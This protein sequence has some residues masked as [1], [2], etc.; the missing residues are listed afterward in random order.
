MPTNDDPQLYRALR[1]VSLIALC[2]S[3]VACAS[4]GPVTV[5]SPRPA[6]ALAR[7]PAVA[8]SEPPPTPTLPVAAPVAAPVETP[9]PPAE[10]PP[11]GELASGALRFRGHDE[12]ALIGQMAT[13]EVRRVIERFNS[14]TLVFHLDL[15]DGY[16]IAFKPARRGEGQWWR[17][18]I[19]GYRLARALQ[20]TA[21]VPPAVSRTVPLRVLEGYLRDANLEVDAQGN[22]AGAAI[23][24][25]P[26][27][28]RTDLQSEA[29]RAVWN[30]WL[31]PT[32]PIAQEHRRR[33][34]QLATLIVFDYLQANF[35]RWNSANIRADEGDDLVFRDNNRAWYPEN[36]RL[37]T[38]GGLAGIRRIPRAL[39]A[40]IE[41][42]TLE[43]LRAEIRRDP[44]S[45]P[46]LRRL[47]RSGGRAYNFRR[48]AL[49]RQID[50]AIAQYGAHNVLIDEN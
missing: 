27:L 10:A 16:E 35:D 5:V 28:A 44:M 22:V 29:A 1:S 15:G 26:T 4:A 11:A 7:P 33:A 31:D 24:W 21:R 49:L 9:A 47:A 50:A 19:L 48:T 17:H 38:R 20:I 25:M 2:L 32:Q 34:M 13:R 37:I 18:E 14:S 8:A 46:L 41:G 39:R 42:A 12:D 36:L 23:Y 30:Q 43:R 3:L 40:A 45:A 6:A